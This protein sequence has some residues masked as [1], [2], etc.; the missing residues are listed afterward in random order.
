[1]LRGLRQFDAPV[2]VIVTEDRAPHGGDDTPFDCGAVATALGNAAWS[3]RPGA[4]ISR[5]GIMR[6]PAMREPADITDDQVIM[7]AVALGWPDE[8]FP[9]NAVVSQRKSVMEAAVFVSFDE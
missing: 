4:V 1:M 8:R 5:Q 3:R 2:C 7:K 9:A 6:S